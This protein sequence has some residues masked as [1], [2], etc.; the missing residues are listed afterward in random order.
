MGPCARRRRPCWTALADRRPALDNTAAPG[1][2]VALG[3]SYDGSRYHGWQS[4]RDGLT[5]QDAL[6]ADVPV[7]TLCAG[8]TDSGVHAFNQVVHFDAP[9]EREAFSWVR[10]TNRYLPSAIGVQ[11]CRPVSPAFHARASA[12][13]RR[14]RY[15]VLES[16]VKPVLEARRCGWT[17]RPLSGVAMQD[18][19]Q[20]LLGEHDFSAFRSS[21]CQALSPVKTLKQ[22]DIRRQGDYWRFDFDANAFLHH[23][24]RNIMGC[25]V[26]IGTGAQP[27]GWMTEV[28]QGR[29]RDAAA[30][31]FSADGLYFVGP[32]YHPSHGIP[33]DVPALQWHP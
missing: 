8:R 22:L 25:L 13:G 10:G 5:V 12:Q 17:F 3:V 7:R 28:L 4:Q 29:S 18:A 23:M 2:R 6:E 19:A 14:Y 27:V 9:V 32:Y 21:E 30:P 16:P 11:W 20:L 1:S 24:V 15:Y 26:A 33:D 31:T